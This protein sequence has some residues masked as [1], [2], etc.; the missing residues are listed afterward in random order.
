MFLSCTSYLHIDVLVTFYNGRYGEEEKTN[1]ISPTNYEIIGDG[2]SWFNA[3]KH[4][5]IYIYFYRKAKAELLSW[6]SS[7][8]SFVKPLEDVTLESL[9]QI[10]ALNATTHD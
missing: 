7:N 3:H 6:L 10:I 9:E 8:K 2:N 4:Q 5:P 1:K